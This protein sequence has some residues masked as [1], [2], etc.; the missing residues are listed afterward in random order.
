MAGATA[1]HGNND[2]AD[3][4]SD[5]APFALGSHLQRRGCRAAV[6]NVGM[7]DPAVPVAPGLRLRL[8]LQSQHCDK[9]ALRRPPIDSSRCL[10]LVQPCE[11][12]SPCA[13][14]STQLLLLPLNFPALLGGAPRNRMQLVGLH[15]ATRCAHA[16]ARRQDE[17]R[18]APPNPA[19]PLAIGPMDV[20]DA[21][22]PVA[23]QAG[24][25]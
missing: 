10:H 11:P 9:E 2:G 5:S 25:G 23:A 15:D 24:S 19:S 22:Y 1:L 3:G 4:K 21:N 18:G 17:E 6:V 13:L 16:P 7:R 8:R 12:V 20:Q 14:D